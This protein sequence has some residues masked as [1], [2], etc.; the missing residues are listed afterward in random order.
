MIVYVKLTGGPETYRSHPGR[1]GKLRLMQTVAAAGIETMHRRD[2]ELLRMRK[3]VRLIG[4]EARRLEPR[5][6]RHP[7]DRRV[8]PLRKGVLP[9]AAR[10]TGRE[11]PAES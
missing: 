11:A 2:A 7:P 8:H 10:S 3:D 1:L 6:L 4:L 9:R 5:L